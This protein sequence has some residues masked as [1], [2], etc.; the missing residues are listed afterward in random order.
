M[1]DFH[2]LLNSQYLL[3]HRQRPKMSTCT[4]T[5]E[6][7][8]SH[9]PAYGV[10]V[11]QLIRYAR[12]ST[13]YTDFLIRHS[14]LRDRPIN[15]GFKKFRLIRSLKKFFNRYQSLVEKFE[16]SVRTVIQDSFFI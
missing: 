4:Y 16:V 5:D 3:T 6:K 12:A 9:I 2:P 10:H 7:E 14:Y 1:I 8:W 13:N 11:S 15:Q